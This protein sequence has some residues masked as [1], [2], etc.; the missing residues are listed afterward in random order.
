MS[1][2]SML[3]ENEILQRELDYRKE[4]I[5]E[6]KAVIKQ[7]VDGPGEIEYIHPLDFCD[8]INSLPLSDC[9][10]VFRRDVKEQGG[11]YSHVIYL[12]AIER[13]FKQSVHIPYRG[14]AV[15]RYLNYKLAALSKRLDNEPKEH[16]EHGK[17]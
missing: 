10:D 17:D 11:D 1:I 7:L 16:H 3:L 2:S 13:T 8:M 6:Q 15:R 9:F 12:P 4:V 5:E 14:D